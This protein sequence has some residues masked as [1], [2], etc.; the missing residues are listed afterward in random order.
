MLASLTDLKA[1][2]KITGTDQDSFLTTLLTNASEMLKSWIGR[3]IEAADYDEYY[4]GGKGYII[5]KHWPVNSLTALKEVWASGEE[6]DVDSTDY[7]LYSESGLI[8]LR[9]GSFVDR[10]QGVHVQYNAGWSTVPE[11]IQEATLQLASML[12]KL[13]DQGEGRLGKNSISVPSGGTL[14]YVHQ[15]P[16]ATLSSIQRYRRVAI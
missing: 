2:L 16:E 11:E 14:S 4:D 7:V 8:V 3:E 10:L 5:L 1:R 15:L 6:T 13:A 12:Y 9:S